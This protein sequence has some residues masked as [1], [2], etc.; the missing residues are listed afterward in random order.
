VRQLQKSLL[1][2]TLAAVVTTPV[3]GQVHKYFT[4]GTVWTVTMI[5]VASG[6]DQIYLQYLDGQFKK[7][8]D[9]NIKAGF[10]KSYKILRTLDDG[11]EWNM[12]ILREYASLA[13]LEANEEKADAPAQQTQGTDQVQMQGYQDRSK[14]R[15]VVG[16][17]YT[18]EVVLK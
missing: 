12:L 14:Y 13:A 18:R 6:M 10:Q 1:V 7:A 11:G 5:R 16:T 17:K 9:A 3:V 2:A 8:E 4:P 15:E